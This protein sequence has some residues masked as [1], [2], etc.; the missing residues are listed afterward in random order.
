MEISC[1]K[2]VRRN[3]SYIKSLGPLGVHCFTPKMAR[4]QLFSVRF[5]YIPYTVSTF[6]CFYFGFVWW[7]LMDV[8]KSIRQGLSSISYQEMLCRSSRKPEVR[9]DVVSVSYRASEV[10]VHLSIFMY[11]LCQ[12]SRISMYSQ[13]KSFKHI[14]RFTRKNI[15]LTY[16]QSMGWTFEMQFVADPFCLGEGGRESGGHDVLG[17]SSLGP[18]GS[19]GRTFS[20]AGGPQQDDR[21]C[22]FALRPDTRGAS[23]GPP[24][25][26]GWYSWTF[27]AK[28][29]R[30]EMIDVYK[31]KYK[32]C[33]I[34]IIKIDVI[35]CMDKSVLR[36]S[37]K[38]ETYAFPW[39]LVALQSCGVR[40]H[41]ISQSVQ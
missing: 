23:L 35:Y 40:W 13:S 39:L 10:G 33:Y 27:C 16:D 22:G 4:G 37:P 38:F 20:G 25:R 18:R 12:F 6:R 11:F 28:L 2:V 41:R 15:I 21:A 7:F 5:S 36:T 34:K 1:F 19:T 30:E 9:L 31:N 3:S 8:S 14:I 24:C 26:R 17:W 29:R 32:G